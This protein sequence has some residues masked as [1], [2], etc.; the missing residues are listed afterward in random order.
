M[1]VLSDAEVAE[2]EAE[3]DRID[4]AARGYYDEAEIPPECERCGGS[5][6][7]IRKQWVSED[8]WQ[9]SG[10]TTVG[11]RWVCNDCEQA[12]WAGHIFDLEQAVNELQ[13]D[14]FSALRDEF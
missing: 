9:W 6:G 3:N 5:F 7:R 4:L 8:E 2:R 1:D 11:D 10:A 12:E 13:E 14:E